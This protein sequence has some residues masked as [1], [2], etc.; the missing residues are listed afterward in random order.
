MTIIT[1][2]PG[3]VLVGEKR[4]KISELSQKRVYSEA[5]T[6]RDSL[7]TPP[8]MLFMPTSPFTLTGTIEIE[9]FCK[10]Y[11]IIVML[12]RDNLQIAAP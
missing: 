6:V 9:T 7:Q 11:I 2:L 1:E 5:A 3:I 4:S 10:K 12:M 8:F